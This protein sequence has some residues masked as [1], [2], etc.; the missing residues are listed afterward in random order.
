M[1]VFD[2]FFGKEEIIWTLD[3]Y[4]ESIC[5]SVQGKEKDPDVIG[6][7]IK[8]WGEEIRD[9]FGLVGIN[10]A[11]RAAS[12]SIENEQLCRI[13]RKAWYGIPGW[14]AAG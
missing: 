8:K 11:W 3:V 10:H 6:K 12:S 7:R 4:I 13:I 5:T 1:G 14:S 9:K 2:F